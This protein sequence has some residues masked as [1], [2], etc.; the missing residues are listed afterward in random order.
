[1]IAGITRSPEMQ[2]SDDQM[3]FFI[4]AFKLDKPSISK[5][6]LKSIYWALTLATSNTHKQYHFYIDP[7]KLS[8]ENANALGMI[9]ES[10]LNSED[11]SMANTAREVMK[12]CK[13]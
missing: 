9:S 5:S 6:L 11:K 8:V 10:L 1:M 13:A 12:I 2:I 3:Q 4:P 7:L